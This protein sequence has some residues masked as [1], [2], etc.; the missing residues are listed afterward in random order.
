MGRLIQEKI[1]QPLAEE[2]LFGKLTKG[3]LVRVAVKDDAID[4]QVQEPQKPRLTGQIVQSLRQR[5]RRNLH[6]QGCCGGDVGRGRWSGRRSLDLRGQSIQGQTG[7]QG[8]GC[9]AG[10]KA[11][12]RR[13]FPRV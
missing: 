6:W 11:A 13:K 12:H 4:L 5:L 3:G 2:L 8:Q 9:G 7:R 10:A 1:K